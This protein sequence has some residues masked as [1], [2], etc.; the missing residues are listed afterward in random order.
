MLDREVAIDVHQA[1]EPPDVEAGAGC[2]AGAGAKAAWVWSASPDWACVC[3]CDSGEGAGCGAA[4]RPFSPRSLGEA[5]G[6]IRGVQM[7]AAPVRVRV[8]DDALVVARL[9]T[10]A[11]LE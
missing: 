7:T 6:G 11:R 10:A 3:G 1:Q 5:S 9:A 4:D 8:P 2:E